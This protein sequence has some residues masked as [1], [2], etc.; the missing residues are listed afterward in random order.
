MARRCSARI[1]VE[2]V[3]SRRAPDPSDPGGEPPTEPPPD[4]GA[5]RRHQ[6]QQPER[7]GDEPGNQE[8]KS[9]DREQAAVGHR[10][11]GHPARVELG[12]HARE[13]ADPLTLHQPGAAERDREH[14]R[15][16][17]E[18]PDPLDDLQE[19]RDLHERPQHQQEDDDEH[20]SRVRSPDQESRLRR[21]ARGE[22]RWWCRRRPHRGPGAAAPPRSS[23][24]HAPRRDG[25]CPRAPRTRPRRS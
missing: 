3:G 1:E 11:R 15:E 16:G 20:A 4:A 23:P 5:H 6:Q 9:G 8:Q 18:H 19:D 14:E 2:V 25:G 12:A 22:A 17:V 13:R 7:I 21:R 10:A 24:V